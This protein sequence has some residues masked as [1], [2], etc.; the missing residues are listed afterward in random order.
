MKRVIFLLIIAL[1]VAGCSTGS[2][3][4][5]EQREYSTRE[6]S[7][8]SPSISFVVINDSLSGWNILIQSEPIRFTPGQVGELSDDSIGYGVLYVNDKEVRRLY[9]KWF[10]IPDLGS[11]E[12]KIEVV[13]HSNMH[14]A[15]TSN[16]K[17]IS[18]V[19]YLT[20]EQNSE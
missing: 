10:H 8:D 1:F 17:V 2:I 3:Y 14:E 11:G 6:V 13:M 12:H 5:Q 18:G 16:G 7:Y 4:G 15:L 9:S 20:S 19:T